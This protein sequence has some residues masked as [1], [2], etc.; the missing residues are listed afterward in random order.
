MEAAIPFWAIQSISAQRKGEIHQADCL[1]EH[2]P[3]ASYR[4]RRHHYE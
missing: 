3:M 4:N 1:L 2:L